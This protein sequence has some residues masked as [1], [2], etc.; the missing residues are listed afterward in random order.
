MKKTTNKILAVA[1]AS[2]A[3]L[4]AGAG[5]VSAANGVYAA[6]NQLGFHPD[7]TTFE[8]LENY[9]K[10]LN[11]EIADESMV[12]LKNKN[13][14]LPLSGN[15]ITLFGARSYEPVYGGTGS[16]SVS[17]GSSIVDGLLA[18]GFNL[19][20][21]VMQN[22]ILNRATATVSAGMFGGASAVVVDNTVDKV[23]DESSYDLYDDAAVI[24]IGRA[25][26]EGS[27]L[28]TKNVATHADK[29][30]HVL[31]LDDNERELIKHAKQHFSKV[32]VLLN[33][34]NVMELGELVADDGE[35]SVDAI[36]WV[37]QGGQNG[38][39]SVGRIL[40]G[41][42]NPSGRT[43]D[44][45][46]ADFKKDPTWQNFG[47]NTQVVLG[48][49]EEGK[50][51]RSS[52]K[53]INTKTAEGE[54]KTST[55]YGTENEEGIY[56]GYK[57]YETRAAVDSSFNYDE[58]VVF[59]FGYGLS[60]S[61]FE[62][63]LA[64]TGAE[65]ATLVNAASSMDDF[66]NVPVRVKNTGTVAG[67]EVV[68]LYNHAPY[69]TNEI[70]KSEVCFVGFGKT[71]LLR[72]GEQQIVNVKV[73]VGDLASFDYNDANHNN[74]AGW[75]LEAGAYQLRL[76]KDSH[77]VI[78]SVDVT[79]NA[80][81]FNKTGEKIVGA[82]S[83]DLS[84]N[85]L[86]KGDDYDTLL[87][88]KEEDSKSK[89]KLMTRTDFA[90]TFPTAPVEAER[91]YGNRIGALQTRS[92][93]MGAS[94]QSKD[95][96]NGEYLRY[97]NY[98]NASDDRETD[99]WY[100]TNA[101]IP[102]DWTQATDKTA[103]VD[104][105]TAIQLFEMAGIDPQSDEVVTTQAGH[106]FNGKTGREAWTMFMNQLT[107]DELAALLANGGYSTP[108]LASVGKKLQVD[109]DGPGQLKTSNSV[110]GTVA[111]G[112]SGLA[113]VCETN[114]A[115]T[116]NKDLAYKQGK[117]VG[118]ESLMIGVT[119]W[120]GPAMNTH[121][122]P[123]AGRNF[124]YYS[125]DGVHGGY[126]AA[127][128]VRGAQE[129]GCVVYLKHYSLN[130]QETNRTEGIAVFGTEQS[131]RENQ[132]KNFEYATKY[133]N[134][135]GVMTAFNS[136]GA[137]PSF[138]NYM[139]NVEILREEWGF[140]GAGVTDYYM[141][142]MAYANYIQR[143]GC[144]LLLNTKISYSETQQGSQSR[145]SIDG[146]WDASLREGKG[147]VLAGNLVGDPAVGTESPT[148]Y[149]TIRNAAMNVLYSSANSNNMQNGLDTI[150]ADGKNIETYVADTT[151]IKTL[152]NAA[153]KGS[154]A[155]SE[156]VTKGLPV[157]YEGV[158]LPEGIVVDEKTGAITGSIK[159]EFKGKITVKAIIDNWLAR[160]ATI[161]L[162]VENLK[163]AAGSTITVNINDIGVNIYKVGDPYNGNA[164]RPVLTNEVTVTGEGVVYD[165]ETGNITV[166]V[167]NEDAKIT[168]KQ[169]GTYQNGSRQGNINLT[170]TV[171]VYA[172]LPEVQVPESHGGIVS[173]TINESGELVIEY[174]DG[175]VVNLGV[176]VGQDGQD[177]AKGDKG[178]TGATGP[179]GDKGD[180]GDTGATGPQGPAG[181]DGKDGTDGKDGVDGKGCAGSIV[182]TTTVLGSLA[183][184][185][186]AIALK[187]KKEE[188]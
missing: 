131:F 117:V 97:N 55:T 102:A 71:K 59:P 57:Y 99:P 180:K 183:L 72:P 22:T 51:I 148:Q 35:L 96:P 149:F 164:S 125:Q 21:K 147:G 37:G 34:A 32:V 111:K 134:A 1:V 181:A 93:S 64:I 138:G 101:D 161:D 45:W 175:T 49:D 14:A 113:W 20:N 186:A 103:R 46:P 42:V 38:F 187:K 153:I 163:A 69:T 48:V 90:G 122:S 6:S 140:K 23:A 75:E 47:D 79:L 83:N 123:F 130:D 61:Q 144:E 8:E 67:K 178:D 154:A 54:G 70:E 68:Q 25:G 58:E 104:G 139:M 184:G 145:Q 155:I 188:K 63:H 133:G 86:S 167:G 169:T 176:V 126:I 118:N 7:F 66:I 12:L 168:V 36:L 5:T 27:D 160:T 92:A 137:V 135:T 151:S 162:V 95:K 56:L 98:Y 127:E 9:A 81:A 100:K 65:V 165:P 11:I 109:Q 182:A 77:T 80:G 85:V 143:G 115:S 120:Y 179:K 41:T 174:E 82:L 73:R 158:N 110:M 88:M 150:T 177:G 87:N 62:Q 74:F 112:K 91:D 166:E 17:S 94:G 128:V 156:E 40:N 136:T 29:S 146:V 15:N 60:Y 43:S 31:Q 50:E 78:D 171:T 13:N 106:V 142:G 170:S 26:G 89:M 53:Y 159:E 52:N 33:I 3:F 30:D 39:E 18:A 157:R 16:G 129:K 4:M 114:V 121:R 76:Q 105:K 24:T 173:T 28:F 141:G 19:N 84:Y 132:L 108:A 172:Q 124:E 2:L 116:F 119:G 44:I 10:S 107:Y 152:P 185:A